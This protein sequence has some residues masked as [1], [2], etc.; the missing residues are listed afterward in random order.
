MKLFRS[1][2]PLEG[3]SER[4]QKIILGTTLHLESK[5]PLRLHGMM[6]LHSLQIRNED[7]GC[8]MDEVLCSEELVIVARHDLS[9]SLE[10]TDF[11]LM[12]VGILMLRI[13]L[14]RRGPPIRVDEKLL[15][16]DK[17]E[18]LVLTR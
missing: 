15:K 13:R 12:L 3:L 1:T 11:A 5:T 4:S 6:S 14:T 2:H 16:A 9:S 8:R 7:D 17:S 10:Q 18:L